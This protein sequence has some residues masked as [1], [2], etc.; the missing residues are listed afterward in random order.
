MAEESVYICIV[1]FPKASLGERPEGVSNNS[2]SVWMSSDAVS[3]LEVVRVGVEKEVIVYAGRRS[4]SNPPPSRCGLVF[5][6]SR[7]HFTKCI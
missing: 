1:R 5:C 7:G 4:A 6:H 2:V 3:F